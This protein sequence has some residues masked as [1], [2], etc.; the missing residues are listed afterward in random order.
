LDQQQ[1]VSPA[2]SLDGIRKVKLVVIPAAW[3]EAIPAVRA[4]G[5]A[6]HVFA[7]RQFVATGSADSMACKEFMAILAGIVNATASHSDRNDVDRRVVMDEP[8]LRI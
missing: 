5:A 2:G 4:Q 3:I 7:N 1:V 6:I 8:S